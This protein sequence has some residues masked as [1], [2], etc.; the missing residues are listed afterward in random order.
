MLDQRYDEVDDIERARKVLLQLIGSPERRTLDLNAL[1]DSGVR[2]VGRL[3]GINDG[4]LQ[5]SGSLANQCAL[6]DLKLGRLLDV[7]DRFARERPRRRG[8]AAAP[9][10]SDQ[11]SN[12]RPSPWISPERHP[13]RRLGD[14]L[15]R[16]LVARGAGARP[17][18][19]ARH[20]GGITP[21]RACMSWACRSYAG[22]S[23]R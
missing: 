21:S 11:S 6:S 15:A 18:G 17:Q 8:R 20:D 14:R 23:R 10:C 7:I 12:R 13:D 2:L 3:A 5:F 1:T 4:R 9:L 22:A 19:P 16:L